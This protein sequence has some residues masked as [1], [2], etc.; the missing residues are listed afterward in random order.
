MKQGKSAPKVSGSAPYDS[1]PTPR[2]CPKRVYS[3]TPWSCGAVTT[4]E[5]VHQRDKQYALLTLLV[6]VV[7]FELNREKDVVA[8]LSITIK[9]G[10]WN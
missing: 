9:A 3:L 1:F 6:Y 10:H 4:S 7:S 2:G 8:R 5:Y